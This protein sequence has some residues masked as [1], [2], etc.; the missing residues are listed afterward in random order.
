MKSSEMPCLCFGLSCLGIVK[1]FSVCHLTS[2]IC[3]CSSYVFV[4]SSFFSQRTIHESDTKRT[5]QMAN[6]NCQMTNG[7]CSETPTSQISSCNCRL[8]ASPPSLL[9]PFLHP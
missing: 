7:K 2:F 8:F 1:P 3:H 4:D 9:K 5:Q 6:D